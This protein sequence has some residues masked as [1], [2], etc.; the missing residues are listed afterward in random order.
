VSH[1][2]RQ[3]TPAEPRRSVAARSGPQ[4]VAALEAENAK[5]HARIAK[6]EVLDRSKRNRVKALEKEFEE[7]RPPPAKFVINTG[8][9][10]LTEAEIVERAKALGYRVAKT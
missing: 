6:L 1:S 2:L 10:Q 5:L 4:Y 7:N 8:T 3:K 9:H